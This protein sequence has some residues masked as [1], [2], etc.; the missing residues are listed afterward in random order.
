MEAAEFSCHSK[1][2]RAYYQ[3]GYKNL[4]ITQTVKT[5]YFGSADPVG[6][7]ITDVPEFGKPGACIIT[8]VI[9]DIPSN[10]SL[11]ADVLE[12]KEMDPEANILHPEGYGSFSGQ[13]LLLQPGVSVAGFEAKA[14]SWLAHYIT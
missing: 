13:Y 4:V 9:K 5:L 8:G 1:V 6:K 12:I 14:N 11:S 3:K 2:T 7:I 10:T